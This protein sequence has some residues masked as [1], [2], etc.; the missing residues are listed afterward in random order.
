LP[1]TV[2]YRR[3][4]SKK[5]IFESP[6]IC[7]ILIRCEFLIRYTRQQKEEAMKQISK[8][9]GLLTAGLALVLATGCATNAELEKVRDEAQAAQR[10]ASE[11]MSAAQRAQQTAD[12]AQRSA[13]Q[14]NEAVS[15]MSRECCAKQK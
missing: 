14:A 12:S 2:H 10:A 11:A 4:K 1:D 8:K 9:L 7:T 5:A 13:N 3:G 15:R 6:G